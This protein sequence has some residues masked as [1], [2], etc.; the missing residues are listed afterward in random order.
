M[1]FRLMNKGE[2]D[3]EINSDPEILEA[4]IGFAV[5]K[6]T[7]RQFEELVVTLDVSKSELA[8]RA[9]L[10]GLPTAVKQIRKERLHQAM[11]LVGRLKKPVRAG[12][13]GTQPACPPHFHSG[14]LAAC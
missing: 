13:G 4:T 14:L 3:A 8:R 1:L 12:L 5:D 11:Q 2:S 10:L 7:V 9:Y 6:K